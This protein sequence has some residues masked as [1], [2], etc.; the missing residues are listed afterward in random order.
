[1]PLAL[2]FDRPPARL[3]VCC[4]S[5]VGPVRP[6]LV[7]ARV[8]RRQAVL[9]GGAGARHQRL[10]RG[11]PGRRGGLWPGVQGPAARRHRRRHQAPRGR[12]APGLRKRGLLIV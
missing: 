3:R 1:M 5:G 2:L 11:Q 7:G 6:H 8:P 4:C 12:A 9:A 10:R